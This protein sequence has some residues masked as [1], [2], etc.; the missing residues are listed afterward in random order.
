MVNLLLDTHP[1]NKN[2]KLTLAWFAVAFLVTLAAIWQAQ[3]T[4]AREVLARNPLP[5]PPIK[6]RHALRPKVTASAALDYTTRKSRGLT[7]QE[8][9][10]IVEDFQSAGLELGIR[11]AA[12][13]EY[14]VQRRTQDR[15]YRDALVEAWSLTPEQSAQI[16]S[17]LAELYDKAKASFI[18]DIAG[19]PPPI[20][21]NGKSYRITSA[22]PI[23]RLIDVD[24]RFQDHDSPFMPWNL[25]KL[26]VKPEGRSGPFT[27]D[28]LLPRST[29]SPGQEEVETAPPSTDRI[30]EHIR[31][32]HPAE[33]KLQLLIT[34]EK[35][36]EIQVALETN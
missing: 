19:G 4:V 8:I 28:L 10:W 13:E 35:L 22:E 6:T 27:V 21:V 14:L 29:S 7:D 3:V 9:G 30:L 26:P 2:L 24:R 16:T 36:K 15:W 17:K 23:H 12:Q 5:P 34:P 25:T 32:L 11:A 20:E 31:K 18:E 1:M 33:L